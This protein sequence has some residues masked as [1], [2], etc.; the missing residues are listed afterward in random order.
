MKKYC[1]HS[2]E[3]S[4]YSIIAS[5][6]LIG[7]LLVLA[8]S[9]L[10]LVLSEM[11]DGRGRQ[12]YLKAFYGAEAAQELALL[13]IKE[14]WYGYDEDGVFI[15][16]N[17]LWTAN[18]TPE[19]SFEFVSKVTSYSGTLFPGE[20]QIIPLFW[21]PESTPLESLESIEFLDNSW[22]IAWNI[23][24]RNSW[25]SWQGSFSHAANV[26]EKK[27]VENLV[28]GEKEF[29][30][31]SQSVWDFLR[32]NTG[33][34]LLLLNPT[35]MAASFKLHSSESFSLPKAKI[36]SSA[37]VGKYSQNLETSVDNTKFLGILRYS[38]FS[39]N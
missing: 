4:W 30:E 10:S 1:L 39:W 6:L 2:S 25:K 29:Q 35:N 38:V 12:D 13:K 8:S 22:N 18:K 9:T 33:S 36:I 28:S 37:Q 21:I 31:V 5:I 20:S 17:I 32:S 3:K 7:F 26:I 15:D 14:K 23:I 24:G 34:Y 16:E 19:I 11:Q 27:I